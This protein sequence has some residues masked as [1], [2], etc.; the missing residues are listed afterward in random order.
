MNSRL[1]I[2]PLIALASV[3]SAC[4][5]TTSGN[6]PPLN[7]SIGDVKDWR[8]SLYRESG[9][10]DIK[11]RLAFATTTRIALET[12]NEI[13][14]A[15]VHL[16]FSGTDCSKN[17][18]VSVRYSIASGVFGYKHFKAPLDWQSDVNISIQWDENTQTS[19]SINGE[20]VSVQPY[21]PFKTLHI[22]GGSGVAHVKELEYTK[23]TESLPSKQGATQ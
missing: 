6:Y 14:Q 7:A 10:I 16:S 11:M 21:I 2:L 12:A 19:I 4:A 22:L 3:L 18:D 5:T 15:P 17:P 9:R 23:L 1:L 20:K 13:E 8:M